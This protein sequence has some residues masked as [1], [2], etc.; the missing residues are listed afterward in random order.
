MGNRGATFKS[1]ARTDFK[2]HLTDEFVCFG[3]DASASVRTIFLPSPCV[4]PMADTTFVPTTH[5][6]DYHPGRIA[7]M[8][9]VFV[10]AA[11]RIAAVVQRVRLRETYFTGVWPE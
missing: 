10:Q 6:I 11:A 8:W 5:T 7:H 9:A 2:L 4:E 3:D 1:S